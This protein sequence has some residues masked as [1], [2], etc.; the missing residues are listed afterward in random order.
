MARF[1]IFTRWKADILSFQVIFV[2]VH[3][4][5]LQIIIDSQY[6]GSHAPCLQRLLKVTSYM[7]VRQSQNQETD[8]S[9]ILLT[10]LQNIFSFY[11]VLH[12]LVCACVRVCTCS[13]V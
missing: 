4:H 7:N 11:E 12:A 5:Y 13:S 6:I 8:L 1:F 9:V 3:H 10:R 2:R